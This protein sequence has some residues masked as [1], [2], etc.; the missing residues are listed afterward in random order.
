M[1]E[2]RGIIRGFD[3]SFDRCVVRMKFAAFRLGVE[4]TEIINSRFD[5]CGTT[6]D[7]VGSRDA[8]VYD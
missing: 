4:R 1:L 6:R 3:I 2:H 5:D 7:A 8:S